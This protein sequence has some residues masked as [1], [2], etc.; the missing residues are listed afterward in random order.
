MNLDDLELLRNLME[1][2]SIST[3]ARRLFLSAST[4]SYR[5][6]T[7]EKN[8]GIRLFYHT[9]N[10]IILT[11]AGEY[12]Y[13]HICELM[14]QYREI[15]RKAQ[16]IDEEKEFTLG[17]PASFIYRYKDEITRAFTLKYSSLK[18]RIRSCDF[19]EGLEPLISG[20]V[21]Y[22]MTFRCRTRNMP[23]S[24]SM[25]DLIHEPYHCLMREDHDLAVRKYV[26]PDDF[27]SYRFYA[28]E[29][30]KPAIE[31]FMA[32]NGMES[33]SHK[34]KYYDDLPVMIADLKK[35]CALTLTSYNPDTVLVPGCVYKP[36]QSNRKIC[37]VGVNR[38][39]AFDD[40]SDWLSTALIDIFHSQ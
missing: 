25:H 27:N 17:L 15:I 8:L 14:G 31:S 5:L 11:K 26:V 6:A 39:G 1:T 37:Y 22:L 4:V 20:V 36:V 29:F 10:Q 38:N 16:S 2:Q 24:I 3:T 30:I 23:K 21:D 40:I 7:L 28:L 34:I 9:R 32:D 33:I 13:N 18:F 35:D 12:Y 19:R